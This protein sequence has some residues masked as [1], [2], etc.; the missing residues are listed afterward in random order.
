[1]KLKVDDVLRRQILAVWM[2]GGYGGDSERG[3]QDRIARVLWNAKPSREQ[4]KLIRTV[5]DDE[6]AT[7]TVGRNIIVDNIMVA[8][9]FSREYDVLDGRRPIAKS[10]DPN[11]AAKIAA[12]LMFWNMSTTKDN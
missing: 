8:H 2:T 11:V 10:D 4:R 7:P 3:A 6:I 9:P 12:V 1:M 5:I